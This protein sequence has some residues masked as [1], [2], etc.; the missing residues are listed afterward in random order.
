MARS[1]AELEPW[2][3]H[4]YAV[5]NDLLRTALVGPLPG[6]AARAL[7]AGCGTGFQTT[8][9]AE[10]GWQAHGLDLSPGLLAVARQSLPRI[11]LV[12]GDIEALPY[13]ASTFDAIACC[14]S[15]LSFAHDA[16]QALRE[17][18]RVLRPGG[19]LVLECEHKWSLDLGW[20]LLSSLAGDM[21]GYGLSAREAA[22][23]FTLPLGAGFTMDYPCRTDHGAPARW[24][25]R[26]FTRSEL[27]G[28][29]GAAGLSVERWWG[30]HGPTNLIPS[31][32]LHRER[33]STAL[34]RLY[35]ALCRID[36][37]LSGTATG[38]WL[39]NSVVVLA[40]KPLG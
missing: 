32:V 4:L 30:I 38:P 27:T 31:T 16:G 2:Y 35:Q 7:D 36:R 37:G 1:Y 18:G 33:L 14:G 6:A 29:L 22:R 26:L 9:L 8:L 19:R 3:E 11:P 12:H 34:G 24:R 23:P 25:L 10:L 39:A 20:A 28:M 17:L 40:R 5:L 15:T 13:A 21:L